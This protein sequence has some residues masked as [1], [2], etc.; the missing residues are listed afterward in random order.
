M[1]PT[2]L[3]VWASLLAVGPA[4]GAPADMEATATLPSSSTTGACLVC[5]AGPQFGVVRRDGER[6]A[7]LALAAR[8]QRGESVLVGC[9]HARIE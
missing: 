5:H 9:A 4:L 1:R 7:R 2:T 8:N 3:S 6:L